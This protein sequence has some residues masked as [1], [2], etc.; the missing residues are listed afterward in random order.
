VLF[1]HF[2]LG[3]LASPGY[4]TREMKLNKTL[5]TAL[6]SSPASLRSASRPAIYSIV[7]NTTRQIYIGST[8]NLSRRWREHRYLLREQRHFNRQLQIA[9]NRHGES[10]FSLHV[11]RRLRSDAGRTALN[12]AENQYLTIFRQMPDLAYNRRYALGK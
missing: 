1:F 3:G 2:V 6:G 11:L 9:W 4:N 5:K 10:A 8:D 7:N 12:R